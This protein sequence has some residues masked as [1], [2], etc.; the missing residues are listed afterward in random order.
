MKTLY[1]AAIVKPSFLSMINECEN[2]REK[3]AFIIAVFFAA[4]CSFPVEY[5]MT[6]AEGKYPY[7]GYLDCAVKTFQA[8][9]PF[10]FFTGFSLIC[11]KI[12]RFHLS[13]FRV[14][15]FVILSSNGGG[16]SRV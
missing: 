16:K 10:N 9:G 6:D 13:F 14:F 3:R 7:T 12:F 1:K 11:A 8:G 4:A 15:I 5:V 2:G